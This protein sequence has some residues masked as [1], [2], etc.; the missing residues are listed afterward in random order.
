ML[1]VGEEALRHDQMQVVL[2]TRHGDIEQAA[3]FLD[4]RGGADA[5][6]GRHAAVHG[7]EQIDRL[8]LLPLG[9]MDRGQ[10]QVILVEQRHAGLVAGRVGRIQSEFGQ[11]T[12]ARRIPG[13]DLLELEQ[14]CSPRFGIFMNTMRA[15]VADRR[16]VG[17][18]GKFLK[19]GV[20]A[21][22]QFLRTDNG[23]PQGGIISPLLA[24]IAL[25]AI[26]ERYER[27]TYHRSK[28]QDR[29]L[30]DGAAA[31]RGARGR[32]HKARRCVFFPIRYAD[33]FVV[34]VSGTEEDA[35]AEKE[36]LANYLRQTT[37]L[38]LSP[39]KTKITPVTEG[40]EFLG[41][42]VAM[43]WD[44]R[45]GYFPRVEIPKAKAADLRH[46][47]KVL[48]KVNTNLVTLGRKLEELNFILRGWSGYYRHC[49]RAGK[50]FTAIDWFVARRIWCWLR[51]K[52]R[53]ARARDIMRFFGPSSRRP[54]RRLWREGPREQYVL[55]WTSIT[56][57]LLG[58]MKPPPFAI[59]SGEPD[60]Y[61]KAHV[62]FG[63][64]R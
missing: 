8:P 16:F 27:W 34:L 52:Y 5:E 43:R 18:V 28:L 32:D 17:L 29:R 57:F 20:L 61:R 12:L 14:I 6:V 11:E 40:F 64:R 31:A 10:D 36:A 63:E 51:K 54:T 1:A 19:A 50:V 45:Y 58:W 49:A 41:F 44:K 21:E 53:K 37:G 15:R 13:G 23:T 35:I 39:E 42:H 47:I 30:S 9:G 62:R 2:C 24:N 55:A 59:S 46:K 60:A 25:S 56:R 38:E 3:F 26:E 7:V 33:D 22:D 48:T 4:L